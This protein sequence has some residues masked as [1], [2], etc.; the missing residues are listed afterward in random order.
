M[1][2]SSSFDRSY[3]SPAWCYNTIIKKITGCEGK[4]PHSWFY[5]RKQGKKK[6]HKKFTCPP[7]ARCA[8][9]NA[10]LPGGRTPPTPATLL[11]TC[12]LFLPR[13][14]GA[15]MT[16]AGAMSSFLSKMRENWERK[17]GKETGSVEWKQGQHLFGV[18]KSLEKL[19]CTA[20][21]QTLHKTDTQMWLCMDVTVQLQEYIW[22]GTG[23]KCLK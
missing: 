9:I 3:G 19:W 16:T 5:K 4:M 23:I 7:A 20:Q 18:W 10:S 17:K 13:F 1:W 21:H 6:E 11:I 12:L 2:S 15:G 22:V 8:S 14:D